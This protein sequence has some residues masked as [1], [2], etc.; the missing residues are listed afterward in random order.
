MATTTLERGNIAEQVRVDTHVR[1]FAYAPLAQAL[2][3]GTSDPHL[4]V[5]EAGLFA[6]SNGAMQSRH[7]KAAGGRPANTGVRTVKEGLQFY[8]IL[9]GQVSLRDAS[10]TVTLLRTGDTAN[11]PR[12]F[13]YEFLDFS[14]DFE[15]LKIIWPGTPKDGGKFVVTRESPDAYIAGNGPR[16]FFTYRDLGTIEATGRAM[17]IQMVKVVGQPPKTGTG[18]HYH[19]M[20]QFAM[21]VAGWATVAFP[22]QSPLHYVPGDG[23]CICAGLQ[24]DVPDFSSDYA[25]LEM[26][27]P[28]DYDTFAT[29][30][31]Q[32]ILE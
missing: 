7:Y 1:H 26:C 2:W 11:L 17:H 23:L 25:V 32:A 8:Y 14:A 12:G 10:G 19:S 20:G 13:A 16:R 15:M 18:W 29:R 6:A 9:A 27:V 28:A 3:S 4:K 30:P 22:G 5:R 31:P 21:A 24:H